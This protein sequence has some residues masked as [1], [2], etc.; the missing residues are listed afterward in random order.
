M[1]CPRC[2][3]EYRVGFTRCSD[4]NVDLVDHLPEEKPAPESLPDFRGDR[5]EPKAELVVIRTFSSDL[6][7]DLAKGALE[8]AGIDSTFRSD[9]TARRL[10]HGLSF[11]VQLLVRAE[12]AEDAEKI[13][14]MDATEGRVEEQ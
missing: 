6:E 3:A 11:A 1:F 9:E 13:L 14:D 8:A 4:C 2:K 12:D 5:F 10:Y 7:A